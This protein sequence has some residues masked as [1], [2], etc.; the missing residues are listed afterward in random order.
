MKIK[1][2]IKY[3]WKSNSNKT[4]QQRA[5]KVLAYFLILMFTLTILS[6]FADYLL[7]PIVKVERAKGMTITHK[8][9]VN[10][11]VIQNREESIGIIEN[12]K[13]SYVNVYP[14]SEIKEGDTL[15]EA[16]LTDLKSQ[17]EKIEN[18]ISEK[19]KILTRA[20]EDYNLAVS[21]QDKIIE[22]ALDEYKKAEDL[23][24]KYNN[25]SD[26]EKQLLDR[27]SIE[28]DYNL[29]KSA[30]AQAINDK[31]SNLLMEK[32]SLEDVKESSNT[33]E[34]KKKIETLKK[35][36]GAEGRILAEKEG[37][38]S[39]VAVTKGDITSDGSAIYLADRKSGFKFIANLSKELKKYAKQGQAVT[40]KIDSSN[41]EIGDLTI[42]SIVKGE[43]DN[44]NISVMLPSDVGEI[45]DLGKLKLFSK[46]KK[47]QVCVPLEALHQEGQDKYYVLVIGEEETILGTEKVAVRVD[48]S[49]ADKNDTHA[50]LEEGI[51]SNSQKI[52]V[53]SNKIIKEGDRVRLEEE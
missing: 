21:R 12:L 30:Y 7:I 25:A 45:G 43:D 10:G 19:E 24:N 35:I 44:Y 16:D 37:I 49:I 50:A 18:E 4:L 15:F 6:R 28:Y 36:E 34:I 29:K 3:K 38:V 53:S 2:I 51:I 33:D 11:S 27:D 22:D 14:G 52:I 32:R 46:S 23:V 9:E 5:L 42:D 47:Y 39:N 40:L 31:S 20:T 13:V 8:I 26:E 1:E 48:V 17:I 41:S